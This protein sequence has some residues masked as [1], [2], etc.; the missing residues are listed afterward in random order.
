[1]KQ[2]ALQRRSGRGDAG[3][4]GFTLIELLVV[5]AIIAILAALLLSSLQGA[6]LMAQ[7]ANCISNLKQ[8][9]LAHSLYLSDFDKDIP[10]VWA[11]EN[12]GGGGSDFVWEIFLSPYIMNDSYIALDRSVF[13]C[14]SASQLPPSVYYN[15]INGKADTAWRLELGEQVF[16]PILITN[17][18]GF[19]FNAWLSDDFVADGS[20]A[21]PNGFQQ[22]PGHVRR[23]SRTPLFADS[24]NYYTEPYPD[25]FPIA[26]VNLYDGYYNLFGDMSPL[27]ARHGGRPASA[28]PRQL[29][30]LQ[31]LPGMIDMALCDGH[32]DKVPLENLWNYYWNA[33]W[34]PSPR[35]R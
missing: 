29:S 6:K 7:Q 19:A 25:D 22:K 31:A 16:P 3:A 11:N 1:M 5:V 12:E 26:N 8:T 20:E 9:G 13:M 14:P 21:V 34:V 32:V 17:Y 28:A 35:G 24:V 2:A 4:E 23:A 33:I 18:G 15:G 30:P 27:I 10:K